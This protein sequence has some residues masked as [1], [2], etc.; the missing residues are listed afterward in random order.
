MD[1]A[2]ARILVNSIFANVVASHQSVSQSVFQSVSQLEERKEGRKSDD[3]TNNTASLVQHSR[4]RPPYG[5][6]VSKSVCSIC[7]IKDNSISF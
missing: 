6:I 7:W 3:A 4:H 5:P 2:N 1:V